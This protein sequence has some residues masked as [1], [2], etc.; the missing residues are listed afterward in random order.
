MNFYCWFIQNFFKIIKLLILLMKKNTSFVWDK[1]CTKA[2]HTLKQVIT[3][4]LVLQHF[5]ST[6]QTIL[7]MNTFNL[8][9]SEILSQYDNEGVLHSVVF[10]SKCIISAECKYY[11]YNKKLLMIICC[12]EHWQLKLKHTDL[13]IQIFTDYQILRIFIKNKELTYCQIKY[14]NVLLKF[15]F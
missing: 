12:F 15:N 4:V 7:E 13:F 11:I 2:F 14:L 8:I 1:N 3:E 5:N 6:C 9:I 10:Y